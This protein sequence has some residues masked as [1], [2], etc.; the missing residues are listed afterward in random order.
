MSKRLTP[1]EKVDNFI[2]RE[3]DKQVDRWNAGLDNNVF[4]WEA[5]INHWNLIDD[6]AS[7]KKDNAE[8]RVYNDKLKEENKRLENR[9]N[10]EFESKRTIMHRSFKRYKA[11]SK[12]QTI[13]DSWAT[14]GL[15]ADEIALN[16]ISNVIKDLINNE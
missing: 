2:I 14:S 12:I 4:E 11:L 1:Y 13:L 15:I 10:V 3:H 8:L 5:F 7:L 16:Q 6:V 9:I